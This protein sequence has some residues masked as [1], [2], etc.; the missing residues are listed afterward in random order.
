MNLGSP[1][2]W[3]FLRYARPYW[4]Y[5]IGSVITGVLKFTLA[6]LIPLSLGYVLD[7]IIL[8]EIPDEEKMTRL[9][10]VV[11]LL[12]VVFVGRIPISY[13]RSYLGGTGGKS[14]H[15]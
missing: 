1:T 4:P 7:H 15:F 5:V 3:R 13:Y 11:G 10:Q 6:L 2:F 9:F 14:D 12:L 8:A